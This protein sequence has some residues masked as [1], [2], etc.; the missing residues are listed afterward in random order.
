MPYCQNLVVAEVTLAISIYNN[1]VSWCMRRCSLL[2]AQ[3]RT[4]FELEGLEKKWFKE[5]LQTED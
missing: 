4:L 1:L 2:F 5:N 3:T